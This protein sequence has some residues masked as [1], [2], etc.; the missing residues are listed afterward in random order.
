MNANSIVQKLWRLCTVLR[1]DGI[2]YQQYVTELTYLLFLKMMAERNRETGSLPKGLRWAD[3]VAASGLAKLEHYRNVLVTLGAS[4]TRLGR[5]DALVRPPGESA[6]Q[7]ERQRHAD[8]RPLPEMVQE[9]FDNASTFIREPQNL[10]TLVT[11]I[12]ELDWFSEERDQF[13]D[14]YEGLLQKNAEETKRGA[15]QYFTPRVLIEVMV[16]LMQPR[17]GEVI[18]DPAAGTG[19]FLIAADRYMKAGT[20]SYF[21]LADSGAWQKRHAFHG[22]EN[23]PGTLRLLLMNL[24]LHD[25]DSDHVA[26]GDTLSDKG[27]GLGRADLILTNPPFGP[28][29]GAPTR[30][31]LSVTAT[32]SSYQLPFVEHCLRALRP[33]GRAAIVVPDNVLFEDGRGKELRRMMMDWCELH[34]ILRLPTGIF[35]AQ[36]VKTNV[37]FLTRG[38][39]ETGNTKAVWIY[40]LRAQMPKF[41]KTTPL[42]QDHFAGFEK[43]F[44][45]DPH[46]GERGPDE[47]EAGRWRRFTREAIAARGDNLD[48]SWLREAEEE[49]EEGLIEPDD[50]AA[51]IL[52]H[53]QAATLEI[54]ALMA[55]LGDEL[56]EAAE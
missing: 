17:P 39:T 37:V 21:G 12:D 34:T 46:G 51:A 53:L 6:T 28:A 1:K 55:E 45:T 54:E 29:G 48:I 35:Y 44:G 36:G 13:G 43:A 27:K 25:I 18:Q 24:Y 11:A 56:P 26:L 15:G 41:G 32:V 49:A 3:L 16:R 5:D 22:M 9:I 47:G 52:G 2:T 31:D 42:T 38:K 4:S 40:D 33:G 20:D 23:V 19:G 30:D 8:S 7:E 14:L 10:T 50:I